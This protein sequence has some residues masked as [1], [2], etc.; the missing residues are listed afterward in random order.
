MGDIP[1]SITI[2][3]NSEVLVDAITFRPILEAPP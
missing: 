2:P 3:P 1:A